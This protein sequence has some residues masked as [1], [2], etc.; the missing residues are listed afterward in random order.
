M[1][2]SCPHPPSQPSQSHRFIF[3]VCLPHMTL[4]AMGLAVGR[5]AR[6]AGA[7]RC[8]GTSSG[9]QGSESELPSNK[10]GSAFFTQHTQKSTALGLASIEQPHK[11]LLNQSITYQEC[12]CLLRLAGTASTAAPKGTSHCRGG[13]RGTTTEPLSSAAGRTLLCPFPHR[14]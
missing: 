4:L 1:E 11:P 7:L 9:C 3:H 6:K 12:Q 14:L 2:S 5:V 10:P 8:P 13:A